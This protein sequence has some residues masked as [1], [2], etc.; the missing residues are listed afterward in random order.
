MSKFSIRLR[1][2][3][4]LFRYARGS[5]ERYEK[6]F[7]TQ[8]ELFYLVDGENDFISEYG[9]K[10]LTP[11]TL[12][13]IPKETFHQFMAQGDEAVYTRCVFKLGDL[14]ELEELMERKFQDIRFIKDEEVAEI[15]GKLRDLCMFERDELEKQIL[16]K[17][18]LAQLLV[19]ID[20][21]A[22]E[23]LE[24]TSFMSNVTKKTI[25]YIRDNISKPLTLKIIA[26]EL[27]ISP[28]HLSHQFK[29]EMQIPLHQYVLNKRLILAHKKIV[30]KTPPTIAAAE[31]GFKDYSNFFVQYKKRFGYSPSHRSPGSELHDAPIL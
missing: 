26:E 15:F 20:V 14:P 27:H 4:F 23:S 30:R 12:V 3:Q 21:A 28:S 7:H 8:H 17:A 1:Y 13:I 19:C 29:E 24:N 6:E 11:G 31:C 9:R 5:Y 2:D 10:K 25:Q 22:E 16:L 18:Y